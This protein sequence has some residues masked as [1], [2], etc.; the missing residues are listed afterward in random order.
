MMA[1]QKMY[2]TM[3]SSHGEPDYNSLKWQLGNLRGVTSMDIDTAS[4]GVSV[5]F[6]DSLVTQNRVE[7][8]L[9][10]LGYQRGQAL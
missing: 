4:N 3:E 1:I 5:D 6:D 10:E 8:A 2:F 7:S 9:Q